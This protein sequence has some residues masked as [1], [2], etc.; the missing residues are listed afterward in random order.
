[1]RYIVGGAG[2][3]AGIGME[4]GRLRRAGRCCAG[5]A[6]AAACAVFASTAPAAGAAVE[7]IHSFAGGADGKFPEEALIEHEGVLYGTTA[8][9]ITASECGTVFGLTPAGEKTFTYVQVPADGCHAKRL[10]A[11]ADGNLYGVTE[12][13]GGAGSLGTLFRI[14]TEGDFTRLHGFAAAAQ[15]NPKAGLISASDGSFYGTTS[16]GPST[17]PTGIGSV[18]RLTLLGGDDVAVDHIHDFTVGGTGLAPDTA[19]VEDRDTNGVFYGTAGNAVF[20]ITADGAYSGYVNDSVGLLGPIG[21]VVQGSDGLLYGVLPL[22]GAFSQGA[23]FKIAADGTGYDVVHSFNSVAD[24][25][26]GP[27][28]GLTVGS[29]GHLY[30]VAAGIFRLT[31][32]GQFTTLVN[33]TELMAVFDADG[34]GLGGAG[35]GSLAGSL[36]QGSDGHLYGTSRHAGAGSCTGVGT[37]TVIGC[38]TVFRVV[39]DGGDGDGDG[40]GGNGNGNGNGGNGNGNGAGNGNGDGNGSLG[41]GSSGGGGGVMALGATGLLLGLAALYGW[42]RRGSRS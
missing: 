32:A 22:G 41:G 8:D 42:R 33:T 20:R 11:G 26:S 35:I 36:I 4:G 6:L 17:F 13:F 39:L 28:G 40:D 27:R 38:G 19:L 30:G 14:T 5:V 34:A 37:D 23:I 2:G 24:G 21:P 7:I 9:D 31:T 18:F 12:L 25:L 10:A 29:D 1:M 3:C 15:A 16:S